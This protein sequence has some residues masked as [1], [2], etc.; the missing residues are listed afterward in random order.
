MRPFEDT[1]HF[2]EKTKAINYLTEA[3][4]IHGS[5]RLILRTGPITAHEIN[6]H[7]SIDSYEELIEQYKELINKICNDI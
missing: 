1:I 2:L 5:K 4:M 3:S 7:I 6:E